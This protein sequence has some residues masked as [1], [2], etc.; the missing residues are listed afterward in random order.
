MWNFGDEIRQVIDWGKAMGAEAFPP[1][2]TSTKSLAGIVC[3]N[4][5]LSRRIP[6]HDRMVYVDWDGDNVG[7]LLGSYAVQ[8]PRFLRFDDGTG[9]DATR[10][11]RP[12]YTEFAVFQSAAP[13]TETT[14]NIQE[15][16]P[17]VVCS[18]I[19]RVYNYE[20]K[21]KQGITSFFNLQRFLNEEDS[22]GGDDDQLLVDEFL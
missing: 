18:K 5:G 9:N 14:D 3:V 6:K 16:L 4:E 22:E 15:N 21:L 10:R 11:I 2:V 19:S 7:F 8:V 1:Y 13:R 12:F 20:G 17:E